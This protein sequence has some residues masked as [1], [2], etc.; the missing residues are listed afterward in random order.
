VSRYTCILVSGEAPPVFSIIPLYTLSFHWSLGAILAKADEVLKL[1]MSILRSRKYRNFSLSAP[2]ESGVEWSTLDW[3]SDAPDVESK[4][5]NETGLHKV[6]VLGGV[7]ATRIIGV[8]GSSRRF[9]T[10]YGAFVIATVAV[11][12]GHSLFIDYPPLEYEYP[13]RWELKAPFMATYASEDIEK[14]TYDLI[15]T[16]SPA[17][18][19][20]LPPRSSS[21]S[22]STS[23]G[24]A[25]ADMAHE[26]RTK[27][28]T[29]GLRAAASI[30]HARSLIL[31]DGPLYQRP[32]RLEVRRSRYLKE[33]WKRLTEERVNALRE[34]YNRGIAVIG[35][36]KRL[37]K[38]RLIVKAHGTLIKALRLSSPF[39]PQE[40]DHAEAVQLARAYVAQH[41]LRGLDPLLIGPLHIVPPAKLQDKIGVKMP[42][43]VYSYVVIPMLPYNGN[44]DRTPCRVIRLEV[45]SEVYEKEG[46]G[47]FFRVLSEGF[48]GNPLLPRAQVIAD[49]RCKHTC[50]RLFEQ[51]CRYALVEGVEL[52]YSTWMAF[53]VGESY[54][55]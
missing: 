4:E 8:D 41:S 18:Y 28:E 43:I 26:V 30:G 10:P 14:H 1:A 37:D 39:P 52:S 20:Y 54:A 55:E 7:P 19:P 34:A 31:L 29:L 25:L 35:S 42:E 50:K 33:D 9:S 40:N 2:E 49:A 11:T 6:P 51:M 17:G 47:V 3:F 46:L 23:G 53:H 45:L 24:Y 22:G 32:W 15:A 36:V 48:T 27:L 13:V 38:S 44:L 21:T 12:L 5:V 16:K